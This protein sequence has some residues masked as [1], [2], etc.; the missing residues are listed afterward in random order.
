MS[1]KPIEALG[2]LSQSLKG[3]KMQ[4]QLLHRVHMNEAMQAEAQ[5]LVDAR[6]RV[7]SQKTDLNHPTRFH[8]RK[9]KQDSHHQKNRR[10]PS[11]LPLKE[12]GK[13]TFID[14]ST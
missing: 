5:R 11:E 1:L 6:N 3:S 13:G 9:K 10:N 2:S 12:R 4:A 8:S 7:K 14:Y